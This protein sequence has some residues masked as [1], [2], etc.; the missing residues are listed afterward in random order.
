[1]APLCFATVAL[2]VVSTSCDQQQLGPTVPSRRAAQAARRDV[3][4]STHGRPAEAPFAELAKVVPSSAGFV[5]DPAGNIVAFVRDSA[6]M[7][8]IASVLWALVASKRINLRADHKHNP[9]VIVKNADYTFEQLAAWRDTIGNYVDNTAGIGVVSLDLNEATN[10][11]TLGVL[12][13]ANQQQLLGAFAALGVD[14][15]AVDFE[16]A[17][18]FDNLSRPTAARSTIARPNTAAPFLTTINS[19]VSQLVGGLDIGIDNPN[20]QGGRGEC[21]LSFAAQEEQGGGTTTGFIT[22]SHC[23]QNL[24]AFDGNAFYQNSLG[25]YIG[26]EK[27]DPQGYR[28]GIY[29]CN[30]ADAAFVRT[31]AGVGVG[32]GLIAKQVSGMQYDPSNLWVVT[33]VEHNDL[34]VGEQVSWVGRTSGFQVATIQNT[35]VD[36]W[37]SGLS[38]SQYKTTCEEETNANA[39]GGDSGGTVYLP[40]GTGNEVEALGLISGNYLNNFGEL[41]FTRATRIQAD[42]DTENG[43]I[44]FSPQPPAGPTLT[45]TGG[46]DANGHPSLS[47]SAY[48]GA[49]NYDVY[50][51]TV[52]VDCVLTSGPDLIYST[53]ATSYVDLTVI[54]S[55]RTLCPS[56]SYYVT[57]STSNSLKPSNTVTYGTQ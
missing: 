38:F 47:W 24:F 40:L 28:C 2:L 30:V 4:P 37:H 14:R 8:R 11:I 34:Y 50:R 17:R 1:M 48:P 3:S 57:A 13:S 41:C 6:D 39:Q 31:N 18:G 10:R 21:T 12:V 43:S 29:I 45:L 15:K 42:F 55:G 35:C 26:N 53:T 7:Q 46:T 33:E 51:K 36:F 32:V 52:D 16:I 23:T 49:L 56:V 44:F 5:Y 19:S 9:G 20:E 27:D 54:T 22:A 25:T